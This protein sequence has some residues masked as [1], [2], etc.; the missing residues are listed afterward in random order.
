LARFLAQRR[1]FDEAS[2]LCEEYGEITERL[3]WKRLADGFAATTHAISERKA[4]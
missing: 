3:G 2:A 4:T 1:R